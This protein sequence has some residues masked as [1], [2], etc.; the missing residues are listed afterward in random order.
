VKSSWHCL[1]PFLPLL[2]STVLYSVMCRCIPILLTLLFLQTG[3]LIQTRH[4]PKKPRVTCRN[5]CR[6]PHRRHRFLYCCE[7]MF[8]AQLPSSTSPIVACTYVAGMCLGNR[9]LAMDTIP[10][11]ELTE[12]CSEIYIFYIIS[13]TVATVPVID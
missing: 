4:G 6:G 1:I 12:F 13:A 8:T 5:A 3:S 10:K 9:C 7:G 11:L 2:P